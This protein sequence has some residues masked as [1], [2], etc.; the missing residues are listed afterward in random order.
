M[1]INTKKVLITL[2]VFVICV[3]SVLPVFGQ[4]T[5]DPNKFDSA[6]DHTAGGAATTQTTNLAGKIFG[7]IQI[8]GIAVAIIM[9]IVLGCKYIMASPEGKSEVKKS[10]PI[11]IVGAVLLF[12]A[13]AILTFISNFADIIN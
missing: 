7:V 8:V 10:A 11:Y 4:I 12:G 6:T 5:V 1:K 2:A 3:M 13:V 9:L